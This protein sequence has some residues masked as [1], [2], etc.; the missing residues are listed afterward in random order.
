MT[1]RAFTQSENVSTG[2][3]VAL[4]CLPAV[5]WFDSGLATNAAQ[6]QILEAN[7][8]NGASGAAN[9]G[10]VL[11]WDFSETDHGWTIGSGLTQTSVVGE[12]LGVRVD[13]VNGYIQS[14]Q[15]AVDS[16]EYQWVVICMRSQS[17]YRGSLKW[18]SEGD[19]TEFDLPFLLR[20]DDR[21][22]IYNLPVVNSEHWVG[23]IARLMFLPSNVIG[24]QTEIESISLSYDPLG[25]P[26]IEIEYFGLDSVLNRVGKPCPILARLVNRGTQT[27]LSLQAEVEVPATV[28]L[29]PLTPADSAPRFAWG[30][31]FKDGESVKMP[32]SVQGHH[33]VMDGLHAGRFYAEVQRY[34]DRPDSVLA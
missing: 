12:P 6:A 11:Y 29:E 5:L 8:T 16:E 7:K 3:A 30:K 28:T 25:A 4:L 34:F 21:M 27:A 33:A 19:S 24:D 1:S 26:D 10:S 9:E 18:L 20:S 17:G 15:L 23:A 13:R 31:F 2:I 32:L 22:H 14:S